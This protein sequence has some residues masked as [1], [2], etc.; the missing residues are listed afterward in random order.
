MKPLLAAVSVLL[1]SALSACGSGSDASGASTPEAA[2]TS[3]L[4]GLEAGDCDAV[5]KAVVTPS[6][7]DCEVVQSLKGSYADEGTDIDTMSLTAGE[8]E[9]DSA[10]V[11][12]GGSSEESWNVERMD[13]G[14]WRVIFDTEE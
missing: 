1:V 4:T 3:F 14:S 12:L 7:V 13:D 6:T 2:V 5:K 11:T 8:V 9:G 10:V